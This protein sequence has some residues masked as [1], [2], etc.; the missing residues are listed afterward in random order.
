MKTTIWYQIKLFTK[1]YLF[2]QKSKII[3]P[4]LNQFYFI[5]SFQ[6]YFIRNYAGNKFNNWFKV[7][8][9]EFW[10]VVFDILI[11]KAL[12]NFNAIYLLPYIMYL[13]DL[14]N[15]K[16][17]WS[18]FAFMSCREGNWW[19]S[20]SA[21]IASLAWNVWQISHCVEE[22]SL[23]SSGSTLGDDVGNQYLLTPK[24]SLFSYPRY[25][26]K[27]KV[28]WN[29]LGSALM[30]RGIPLLKASHLKN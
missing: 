2:I 9:P 26:L 17:F 4:K 1:W 3:S 5:D 16:V 11:S 29:H 6:T 12:Q 24:E 19:I 20:L 18:K 23:L 25:W 28:L 13:F 22:I 30:Q 14:I 10:C 8:F 21:F 15:V 7:G 27:I